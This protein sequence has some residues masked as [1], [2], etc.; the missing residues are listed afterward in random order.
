MSYG[1]SL[2]LDI[3]VSHLLSLSSSVLFVQSVDL[4]IAGISAGAEQ[5]TL[6]QPSKNVPQV[7]SKR[8]WKQ[9]W[10]HTHFIFTVWT[11]NALMWYGRLIS[12]SVNLYSIQAE[13]ETAL[14]W[15]PLPVS[16]ILP[17]RPLP[18]LSSVDRAPYPSQHPIEPEFSSSLIW[19]RFDLS[20]RK[21]SLNTGV[22]SLA[23][24]A[25]L[26]KVKDE[27]QGAWINMD[28]TGL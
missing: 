17:G 28:F 14:I 9:R 3:P 24:A 2:G 22:T 20:E 27:M 8:K 11:H 21:A 25:F 16:G 13:N 10:R 5:D 19:N 7:C 4:S 1:L 23:A 15:G 18:P 26:A 6:T 12:S